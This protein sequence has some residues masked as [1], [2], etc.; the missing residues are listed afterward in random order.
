[1]PKPT[2]KSDLLAANADA[3]QSLRGL[4][5]AIS[6]AQLDSE[7]PFPHCDRNVRD[8]LAHVYEWQQMFF[9]WYQ[10]GMSGGTPMMPAP[11]FT[12]R[13]TPELNQQ[14]WLKHQSVT[15]ADV[16]QKLNRSHHKLQELIEQHSDTEL[17]TK[18]HYPWTGSTSLGAYLT[19]P[20]WS[21]YNWA[22][23]LLRKCLKPL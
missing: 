17:F 22:W 10:V 20:G 3:F 4:L 16:R 15:I 7:F 9:G 12:W 2:T 8:V 21:H 13:T 11:G 14:I 5:A 1:M 18:R 19:S 23:K 6:K